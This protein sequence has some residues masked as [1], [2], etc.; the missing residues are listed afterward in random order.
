[1]F[2]LCRFDYLMKDVSRLHT[3]NFE[4]H[5]DALNLKLT[6]SQCK[7]LGYMQRHEGV[8]QTRLAELSDIGPMTMARLLTQME[9]D[10]LVERRPDPKD[11]RAHCMYL[12]EPALSV[13]DEIWRVSD[14][15]R[16]ETLGVLTA[17][18]RKLLMDLLQ[19]V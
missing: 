2:A 19:R 1:M 16:S 14:R 8:S 10:G 18:E 13:L 7:V 15:V 12:R 11:G 3:Q 17:V 5:A 4:R 9:R 6:L